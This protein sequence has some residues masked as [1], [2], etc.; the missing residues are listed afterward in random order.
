M[1]SRFWVCTLAPFFLYSQAQILPDLL[2][3]PDT[4]PTTMSLSWRNY[5]FETPSVSTIPTAAIDSATGNLL[6]TPLLQTTS[7]SPVQGTDTN[8]IYQGYA[9]INL[10]SYSWIRLAA[11]T[12]TATIMTNNG[13][14]TSYVN[15][16]FLIYSKEATGG[17]DTVNGYYIG[18]SYSNNG[19]VLQFEL[20]AGKTPLGSFVTNV[21]TSATQVLLT[22]SSYDRLSAAQDQ[23]VLIVSSTATPSLSTFGW[24]PAAS[25][26]ALAASS[27]LF[28]SLGDTALF[29]TQSSEYLDP[30]LGTTNSASQNV[31]SLL[32][33]YTGTGEFNRDP[34]ATIYQTTPALTASG[35][36]VTL[37][38]NAYYQYSGES[39]LSAATVVVPEGALL[40]FAGDL[41]LS[42]GSVQSLAGS[43]QSVL[44]F[45]GG[46]SST[47]SIEGSSTFTPD[48]LAIEVPTLYVTNPGSEPVTLAP[49]NL[50]LAG[51]SF[52][53]IQGNSTTLVTSPGN[54]WSGT[55]SPAIPKEATILSAGTVHFLTPNSTATPG[56]WS[57]AGGLNL[58]NAIF[59]AS[60]A[61]TT[62]TNISYLL[63]TGTLEIPA[64]SYNYT[65]DTA[66]GTSYFAGNLQINGALTLKGNPRFA[67]SSVTTISNSLTIPEYSTFSSPTVTMNNLATTDVALNLFG[68]SN[69][70]T[71]NL[72]GG[73][74]DLYGVVFS[75]PLFINTV[76]QGSSAA[77]A[78]AAFVGGGTA[79][80]TTV[81]NWTVQGPATSVT[82]LV[83][84]AIVTANNLTISQTD[85]ALSALS[86][87][88][89]R[90]N[91]DNLVLEDGGTLTWDSS[92]LL[93]IVSS[94]TCDAE[95]KVIGE[96]GSIVQLGGVN[97]VNGWIE[98]D[99]VSFPLSS[100]CSGTG[101]V[102]GRKSIEIQPT[103]LVTIGEGVN[104]IS[105]STI[106]VYGDFVAS[107]TVTTPALSIASGGNFTVGEAAG[108]LL[109][110]YG[111]FFLSDDTTSTFYIAPSNDPQEIASSRINISSDAILG[112]NLILSN[113][114]GN[115]HYGDKYI[116]MKASSFSGSFASIE[117]ATPLD[118]GY[119]Y[120]LEIGD[121]PLLYVRITTDID[122]TEGVCC[123]NNLRAAE[124]YQ[125]IIDNFC[126]NEAFT[127]FLGYSLIPALMEDSSSGGSIFSQLSGAEYAAIPESW[128]ETQL[129]SFLPWQEW[130]WE[131]CANAQN[132]GQEKSL[133][134]V[135]VS[136]LQGGD[137]QC[138]TTRWHGVSASGAACF[139]KM[140]WD[141]W[142][143]L[144]GIQN[145]WL[146]S[147]A[148][149]N[150]KGYCS[151]NTLE[152]IG[153]AQVKGNA[154]WCTPYGAFLL[155][156]G[157]GWGFMH[158]SPLFDSFT[159]HPK[160]HFALATWKGYVEA[161]FLSQ[162][163]A[164]EGQL[165]YTAQDVGTYRSDIQEEGSVVAVTS[166]SLFFS[167]FRTGLGGRI[168]GHFSNA[169]VIWSPKF[170]ALGYWQYQSNGTSLMIQPKNSGC[171]N[172]RQTSQGL[173]PWG[174]FLTADVRC[175]WGNGITCD[176][177]L[178]SDLS[179]HVI[180]YGGEFDVGFS[181]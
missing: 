25:S 26:I 37:A 175:C 164:V 61:N 86:G 100:G 181:W 66:G 161:G 170:S 48:L 31:T 176:F 157:G 1:M 17:P 163:S 114:S 52:L 142:S 10:S 69:I 102:Y 141:H 13:S 97:L 6:L 77:I 75:N 36:T 55:N 85:L 169:G 136:G 127:T 139:S 148:A 143:L 8:Y 171:G 89:G 28:S 71:L 150:A 90:F 29:L 168:G 105:S 134:A 22:G 74:T 41:S 154:S 87:Q 24:T 167:T 15:N 91:A 2:L 119:S 83:V 84:G 123:G 88:M 144:L 9:E 40:E 132:P 34:N 65:I 70:T 42:N 94:V 172:Y 47:L 95:S 98:A 3:P 122:V 178:S 156:G 138:G 96:T 59:D 124:G 126:G 158:R 50:T 149:D 153:A 125:E 64:S 44:L 121:D 73:G 116:L 21:T 106:G 93:S 11:Q 82:E 111:A 67:G 53:N 146:G 16:D 38:A 46:T 12:P 118:S 133:F 35:T 103:A 131:S 30:T 145:E 7:L 54:S 113:S 62:F 174:A 115:V 81:Q 5:T 177:L 101:T 179:S 180:T 107:G 63:I 130:L 20:D 110:L 4:S 79:T 120:L 135:A 19:A 99:T 76:N 112:G 117:F 51:G 129:I 137:S 58:Y 14:A 27:T 160:S 56:N 18:P 39:S 72:L 140:H 165:Y 33:L 108:D 92:I 23:F 173:S 57:N 152:A 78:D 159:G 68:S 45:S 162:I 49:A 155:G 32:S 147:H 166:D 60:S 80:S 43:G 109:T 151:L 128:N 104:F